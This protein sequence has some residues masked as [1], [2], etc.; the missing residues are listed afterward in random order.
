MWSWM[1]KSLL[2]SSS[3]DSD[4]GRMLKQL[5]ATL[6][7]LIPKIQLPKEVLDYRPISCCNVL[8]MVMVNKM[9]VVLYKLIDP[10]QN[11]FVPSKSISADWAG[12]YMVA[13]GRVG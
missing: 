9:K 8:H 13:E 6:L 3:Y 5:N 7:V 1:L 11:A 12:F 2:K 4:L 10:S